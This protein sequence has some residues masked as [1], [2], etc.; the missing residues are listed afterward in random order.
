MG[1]KAEARALAKWFRL[2]AGAVMLTA[3]G[4]PVLAAETEMPASDRTIQ[5]LTNAHTGIVMN[6]SEW[7]TAEARGA[8][9]IYTHGGLVRLVEQTTAYAREFNG[10]KSVAILEVTALSN[11]QRIRV[12]VKFFDEKR[13]KASPAAAEREDMI[14]TFLAKKEGGNWK[15]EF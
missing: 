15:L 11:G 13:R 1:T 8:K 10:L 5:F 12:Q 2:F 14:W 3:V 7:L 4:S 6:D 9:K